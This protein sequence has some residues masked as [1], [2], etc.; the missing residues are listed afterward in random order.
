[1]ITMQLVRLTTIVCA[2]V[3]LSGCG[4]FSIVDKNKISG[5]QRLGVWQQE[6]NRLAMSPSAS[7]EKYDKAH[8]QITA[9][10]NTL[11]T[12]INTLVANDWFS[13][14]DL[15]EERIPESVT[16]AVTDFKASAGG[17]HLML[18]PKADGGDKSRQDAEN[19]IMAI[20]DWAKN[21][22][23]EWRQASGDALKAKLQELKWQGWSTAHR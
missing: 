3:I 15:T 19:I 8:D 11:E 1:M 12:Q 6:S 9:Y 17:V 13:K 10:I 2:M 23:R 5:L 22:A 18:A 7:K 16:T 20:I 14:I 21:T 4:L